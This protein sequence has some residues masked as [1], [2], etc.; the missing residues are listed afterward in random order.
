MFERAS[1]PIIFKP[2]HRIIILQK[3]LELFTGT[4]RDHICLLT[5]G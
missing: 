2:K 1:L 5:L 4:A 3:T